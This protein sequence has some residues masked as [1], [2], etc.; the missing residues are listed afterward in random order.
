MPHLWEFDHPFYGG[1]G[2]Y[3]ALSSFAELREALASHPHDGSTVIYR[4]DWL[5]PHSRD[6]DPDTREE[7]WI[8]GVFPRKSM[9][10]S[11]SCPISKDQEDEVRDW[12]R[13]PDVLGQLAPVWSPL[14]DEVAP[15]AEA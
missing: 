2:Q 9:A 14:L 8:F 3:E 7:L 5:G 11:L 15:S 4:W 1:D 12:L 13:G 10:W 6:A